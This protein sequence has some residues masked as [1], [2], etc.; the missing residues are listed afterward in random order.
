MSVLPLKADVAQRGRFVPN[1]FVRA[2]DWATQF[3]P[4]R[5][6]K[7]VRFHS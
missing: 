1:V 4:A 6:R 3:V 7:Y 5:R 2:R